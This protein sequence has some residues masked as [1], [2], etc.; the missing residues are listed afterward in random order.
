[1]NQQLRDELL[2]MKKD[3]QQVLQELIEAG[4][5]GCCEYHPRMKAVHEK[6]NARIK[7]IIVKGIGEDI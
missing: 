6:N 3:D 1:M 2:L 7:D 5:L 4:E